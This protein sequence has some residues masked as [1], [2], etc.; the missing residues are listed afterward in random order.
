MNMLTSSGSEKS[1]V[2]LVP[3]TNPN[4]FWIR[5]FKGA[6]PLTQC[7]KQ[8]TATMKRPDAFGKMN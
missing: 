2:P 4:R 5:N 6:D 8:F 7:P 1:D 3:R